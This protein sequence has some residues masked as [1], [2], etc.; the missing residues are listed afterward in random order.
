MQPCVSPNDPEYDFLLS[1][2]EH[3]RLYHSIKAREIKISG[4]SGDGEISDALWMDLSRLSVVLEKPR[5]YIRLDSE[6]NS[7]VQP[8]APGERCV[9]FINADEQMLLEMWQPAMA[10]LTVVWDMCELKEVRRKATPSASPATT[11]NVI[12]RPNAPGAA[13]A[14]SASGA[15]APAPAAASTSASASASAPASAAA[16]TGSAPQ[17]ADTDLKSPVTNLPATTPS[18]ASSAGVSPAPTASSGAVGSLQ[19]T[20]SLVSAGDEEDG[21][22]GVLSVVRDGILAV[23]S[24]ACAYQRTRRA[25][26]PEVVSGI[27]KLTGLLQNFRDEEMGTGRNAEI[28]RR[29]AALAFFAQKPKAQF[30]TKLVC[31]NHCL[32]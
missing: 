27:A 28:N 32:Q 10:A 29:D 13:S 15:A 6:Q 4:Q 21:S 11:T 3:D 25:V 30:A 14:A 31:S 16:A 2:I 22:G 23:L 12:A 1:L 17:T 26:L 8:P 18:A 24:V 9:R 19:R 20:D 7:A 5:H